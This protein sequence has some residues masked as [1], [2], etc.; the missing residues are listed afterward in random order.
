MREVLRLV[1]EMRACINLASVGFESFDDRILHN[2][3]KGITVKTNLEVVFLMRQLKEKFPQEWEYSRGE[4]AIHGFIH[5]TPWDSED[6]SAN[7]QKIIDR[8]RLPV[9]ILPQHSTPLIIHH[10]SGLADWIREVE[11]REMIEFKRYGSV[12][13]WWQEAILHPST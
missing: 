8:Y 11:K 3:N 1:R 5:P 7:I 12:I 2:L 13:G 4:G 10:A 9:D 6:T